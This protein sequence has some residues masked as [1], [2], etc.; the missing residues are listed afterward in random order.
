MASERPASRPAAISLSLAA[1][2]WLLRA[3]V[4]ATASLS[5]PP[6]PVGNLLAN[7]RAIFRG[8]LP[9]RLRFSTVRRFF[10]MSLLHGTVEK[11]STICFAMAVGVV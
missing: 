8:R 3:V 5:L 6:M 10:L 1:R 2:I 9:V 4:I 7:R 11:V